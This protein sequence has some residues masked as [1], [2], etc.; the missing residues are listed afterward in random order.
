MSNGNYPYFAYY[1]NQQYQNYPQYVHERQTVRPLASYQPYGS[2]FSQFRPIRPSTQDQLIVPRGYQYDIVAS[3]G[4]EL[5]NGER[6]GFNNDFTCYFSGNPNEG[7]LW[8]NHEYIGNLSMYV[9]GYREEQGRRTREQIEIEK[10]NVGGSVIHIRKTRDGNWRIVK[11]SRYNRRITANTPIDLTG[12]AKGDPAVGGVSTVIGTFANC[13]GGKTLW[14]TVFSCEENY[15]DMIEDWSTAEQE[16]K[17]EQEATDTTELNATH[18][19]WVVEI[20]PYNPASTPK[21]HTFLGRFAHENAVMTLGRSGHV[22]VYTGDDA[23]DRC[24]YKFVSDD[25]YRPELGKKNSRLLEKGTLYVADMGANEWRPLDINKDPKLRE[26]YQTQGELLVNTRDAA[27]LV[28]GTPLD[29]PEDIEIHPRDGSIYIALTNNLEH[30]NYYG[31]IYRLVE[32]NND[33]E[34]TSFMYEIFVSGGPQSGFAC[35]DNMMFD[36][37]GNLWVT[38]DISSDKLNEGVYEPF[39]NNGF[40]MIPTEGP[41]RGKAMQF[42]SAPVEAELTGPWLAPDGMTLFLSVQHP[43]EETEDPNNPHS[44]WPYGDIPRPSVVAISRV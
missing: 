38:T 15:M 20:D 24:V 18:Y 6:F 28:G 19:G 44:R 14:N 31:Q 36:Q 2:L 3:W 39:G 34:S 43:G 13:S 29:R 27:K 11:G 7:L 42:A 16:R 25:V 40:F 12:P 33:S 9:S 26:K 4:D 22:V 21:K 35:P 10:Y 41:N 30:G 5:G 17:P 23:N 37:A 32:D 1:G 8:V